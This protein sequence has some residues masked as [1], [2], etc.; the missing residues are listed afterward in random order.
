MTESP[1]KKKKKKR[2]WWG[3]LL[4]V[5]GALAIW[6]T[7]SLIAASIVA[8]VPNVKPCFQLGLSGCQDTVASAVKV[9][10]DAGKAKWSDWV[11]LV[12]SLVVSV[13]IMFPAADPLEDD[14]VDDQQVQTT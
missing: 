11:I 4:R 9:D 8:V 6:L 7:I 5:A 14:T 12:V 1:E 10:P 2:T 13:R 3:T